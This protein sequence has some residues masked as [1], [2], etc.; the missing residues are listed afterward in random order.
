MCVRA[1]VHVHVWVFLSGWPHLAATG[2]PG[3]NHRCIRY[4]YIVA[5]N[6]YGCNRPACIVATDMYLRN[7][8]QGGKKAAKAGSSKGSSKGSRPGNSR[9]L[10][11]PCS[12]LVF[13]ESTSRVPQSSTLRPAATST[14]RSDT[15]P[16]SRVTI[17]KYNTHTSNNHNNNNHN[18][19]SNRNTHN[20][21]KD[22][23]SNNNN[24]NNNPKNYINGVLAGTAD[25]H[26]HGGSDDGAGGD[27]EEGGAPF[28]ARPPHFPLTVHASEVSGPPVFLG[29][30]WRRGGCLTAPGPIGSPLTT[31]APGLGSPPPTS[32]PGLHCMV[33]PRHIC[34]GTVAHHGSIAISARVL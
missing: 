27:G 32:V 31:S 6:A 22:T 24:K 1:R 7:G 28:I 5:T 18:T 12:T 23:D 8:V 11:V 25:V 2:R 26:G 15:L 33:D 13:T 14:A 30:F 10:R 19:K 21:N 17:V 9:A 20:H 4:I 29:R 3:R 16:I 34:A